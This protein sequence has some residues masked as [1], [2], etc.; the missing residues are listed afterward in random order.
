MT[1]LKLSYLIALYLFLS[2]VSAQGCSSTLF[3]G[4][5][6]T[7]S[8]AGKVIQLQAKNPN[9]DCDSIYDAYPGVLGGIRTSKVCWYGAGNMCGFLADETLWA[10]A[11]QQV[12]CYNCREWTAVF[13]YGIGGLTGVYWDYCWDR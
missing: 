2:T 9:T 5:Y 12:G 6:W 3:T 8:A 4:C 13:N 10:Y 11:E 7:R 1:N